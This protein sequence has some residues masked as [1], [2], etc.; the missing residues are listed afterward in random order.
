MPVVLLVPVT[1][2]PVVLFMPVAPLPVE[3]VPQGLLSPLFIVLPCVL[4][5]EPGVVVVF[6]VPGEFMPGELIPGVLVPGLIVPGLMA[7]PGVDVPAPAP[8]VPAA[9]APPAAPPPAPPPPPCAYA[10]PMLDMAR[11]VARMEVRM[12]D[13]RM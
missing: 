3:A 9:P 8:P 5:V 7:P 6:G 10:M 2:L 1:P 13:D 4:G 11:A 12:K